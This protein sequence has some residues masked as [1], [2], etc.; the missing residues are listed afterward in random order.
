MTEY[1]VSEA[2]NGVKIKVKLR[3]Q[4]ANQAHTKDLAVALLDKL[5]ATNFWANIH[6]LGASDS[7]AVAVYFEE[8]VNKCERRIN[9]AF[10]LKK[11]DPTEIQNITNQAEQFLDKAI[12]EA[13]AIFDTVVAVGSVEPFKERLLA[14]IRG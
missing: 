13:I 10:F 11:P 4:Y 3:T 5:N 1:I 9:A 8:P 7:G 2:V 14:A 6:S 12:A